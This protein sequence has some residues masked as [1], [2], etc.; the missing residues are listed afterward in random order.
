MSGTFLAY[1]ALSPYALP[2]HVRYCSSTWYSIALRACYT[3]PSTAIIFG[4][5]LPYALATRCP[6]L[7]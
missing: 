3:M 1:G 2:S 6:V 5:V 4:V 7:T